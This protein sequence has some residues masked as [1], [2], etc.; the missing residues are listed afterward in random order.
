MLYVSYS[1][2][3]KI[4]RELDSNIIILTQMI[5]RFLQETSATSLSVI[6]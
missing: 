2:K 5:T 6:A 1:S 4:G 3:L